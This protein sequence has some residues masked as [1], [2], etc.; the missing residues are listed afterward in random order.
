MSPGLMSG[1]FLG[2]N[3]RQ[4]RFLK[5]V[6]GFYMIKWIKETCSFTQTKSITKEK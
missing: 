5:P 4:S 2:A 1:D 3:G 6:L